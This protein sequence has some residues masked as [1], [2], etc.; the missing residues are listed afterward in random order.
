VQLAPF[1]T[2]KIGG[3]AEMFIEPHTKEEVVESFD[4]AKRLGVPITIIGNG[5]KVLISDKGIPGIVICLRNNFSK[6]TISPG[7]KHIQAAAGCSLPR[8]AG[9]A[10][11]N[12]VSGF[13]FL[14]GIPGTV[15]GGI[16]GNAGKGGP[17]GQS[18]KDI[19]IEVTVLNTTNG[20]I[21]T[22]PASQLEMDYR[23]TSISQKGLLILEAK[24]RGMPLDD[25]K[26]IIRTQKEI[27]E[28][29]CQKFPFKSP[30]A[31]SVFKTPKGE[32]PAGW[33]IDQAGLKGKRV[34]GAVV[35]RMHANWIENTGTATAADVIK[36]MEIIENEVFKKYKIILERE[37]R[38]LPIF[39]PRSIIAGIP[40]KKIGE[41]PK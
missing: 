11:R 40:A 6:V 32:K 2:W 27:I 41:V 15:G 20:E 12:K 21:L 35:S 38:L 19:L 5:S 24:F 23:R 30:T 16:A 22:M 25:N 31:G 36:L 13:E 3:P 1:T 7:N 9:F 17:G 34:G 4:L 33:Y 39:P 18:L 26:K 37:I 10:C 29:R 28:G 14:I 8:L